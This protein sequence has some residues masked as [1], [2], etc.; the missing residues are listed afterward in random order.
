[1]SNA[2]LEIAANDKILIELTESGVKH[3]NQYADSCV[4]LNKSLLKA[5]I[6]SLYDAD[7]SDEKY[8]VKMPLWEMFEIFGAYPMG[9][10]EKSF[11]NKITKL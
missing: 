2:Q 7:F 8:T 6:F 11:F 1:M 9:I 4:T 5:A 3:F 10:T